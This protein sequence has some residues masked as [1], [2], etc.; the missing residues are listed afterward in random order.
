M[1]NEFC[2]LLFSGCNNELSFLH[3]E[4][5]YLFTIRRVKANVIG[6]WS[7]AL[8]LEAT[9]ASIATLLAEAAAG[10]KVTTDSAETTSA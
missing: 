4:Y 3:I 8:T 5:L 6:E 2:N 7:V 10:T 1:L 9:C